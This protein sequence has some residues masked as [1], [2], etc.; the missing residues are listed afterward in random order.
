MDDATLAVVGSIA[1]ALLRAEDEAA[2]LLYT[3]LTRGGWG[4]GA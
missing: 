1:A 2:G 4:P 3:Y